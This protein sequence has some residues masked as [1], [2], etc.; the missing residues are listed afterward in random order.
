MWLAL[1]LCLIAAFA[2][3]IG[4]ALTVVKKL[5]PIE[6]M[7]ITGLGTGFLLGATILDRLPD[8]ME[9]LPTLAPLFIITGYLLLLLINQFSFHHIHKHNDLNDK[10]DSIINTKSAVITLIGLLFH[11]FMDGVIIAGSFTINHSMGILIFFAIAMHKIPE[12]FSMAT[13]SLASGSSRKRALLT[14]CFLAL[15]T[16]MGAIFTLQIIEMNAYVIKI[17]MALATGTFLYVST[18]EMVPAIRGQHRGALLFVFIGVFIFYISLL[19][20]KNVGLH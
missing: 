17:F 20:I 12:G 6:M 8:S 14:S 13:I 5:N 4:G 15:S 7:V 16:L 2:D 10:K 18:T 3:V 9:E 11:T 19:L 1:L